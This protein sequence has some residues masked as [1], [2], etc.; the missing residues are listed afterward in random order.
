MDDIRTCKLCNR[1][2]VL[3]DER[4]LQCRNGHTTAWTPWVCKSCAR[5]VEDT[6]PAKCESCN[7]VP[8]QRL[9]LNY[10]T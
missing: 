4:E 7:S 2:A 1:P 8:G 9:I 3:G 10:S 6:A 5:V